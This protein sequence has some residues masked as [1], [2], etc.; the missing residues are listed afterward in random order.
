MSIEPGLHYG[1]PNVVY[2]AEAEHLSSTRLKKSLPEHYRDGDLNTAAIEFGTLVHSVV[3]EPETL[4]R[5]TATRL[6]RW[7]RNKY[8]VRRRK[9]G[10]FP[11]PHL[12]GY[13]GLICLAKYKHSRACAMV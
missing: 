9:G 4:D 1:I 13:F 3:L 5:Y 8:K 2:Q 11:F 10:V 7:L 6:R 12:Y